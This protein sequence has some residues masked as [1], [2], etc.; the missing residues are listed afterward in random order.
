MKTRLARDLGAK[1]A[2][3]VYRGLVEH[4]MRGP[5]RPNKEYAVRICLADEDGLDEVVRWLEPELPPLL[6]QGATLGERMHNAFRAAFALGHDKAL[7]IGTDVPGINR[8]LLLDGFRA[9]DSHDAVLGPAL[10]GGYYL[11]GLKEPHREIFDN[12]DWSTNRVLAQTTSRMDEL[13]LT[14]AFT[15][16]LRDIDSLEDLKLEGFGYYSGL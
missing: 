4:V 15:Q 7:L 14:C 12:V 1:E 11:V 3:A 9:L 16:R 8:D 2:L 5:G 6:Q 13:R 10:D